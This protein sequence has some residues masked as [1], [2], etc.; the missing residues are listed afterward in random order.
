MIYK[1]EEAIPLGTEESDPEEW[2]LDIT[3]G[4]ITR[5]QIFFPWGCFAL[6]HIQVWHAGLQLYPF[7]GGEWLSGNDILYDFT[8]QFVID[9]VPYF[10]TV[11][12]YNQSEKWDHTPWVAIQ[13]VRPRRLPM[14]EQF[15]RLLS[16]G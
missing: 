1:W 5:A 12:G 7:S 11:K 2:R 4:L 14:F 15:L 6:A 16:G 13:V 3:A 8:D 10:L 9:T